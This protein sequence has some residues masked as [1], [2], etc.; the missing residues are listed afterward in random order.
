MTTT[1]IPAHEKKFLL[2][3]AAKAAKK[4]AKV[5]VLARVKEEIVLDVDAALQIPF[6]LNVYAYVDQLFGGG[7]NYTP[8]SVWL[9]KAGYCLDIEYQDTG[10]NDNL[11]RLTVDY[12]E[13]RNWSEEHIGAIRLRE[14]S[15]MSCSFF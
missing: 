10:N 12:Y 11:D 3:E 1:L 2:A 13:K 4:A 15:G 5:T 6:D 14:R 8:L 9:Q 7:F